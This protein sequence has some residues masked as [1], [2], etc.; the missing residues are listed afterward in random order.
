MI[1]PAK[2]AMVYHNLGVLLNAGMPIIKSFDTMAGNS[3][4]GLKKIF[5]EIAK[6]LSA[7]E[8][9]T[10]AM[11]RYDRFFSPLD[12][13]MVK[14]GDNSGRLPQCFQLLSKWYDFRAKLQRIVTSGLI[15]PLVILHIAIPVASILKLVSGPMTIR[16]YIFDVL[17]ALFTIY[18]SVFLLF[19]LYRLMRKVGFINYFLDAVILLVP[20]LGRGIKHLSI[21]KYARAFGMLYQSGVPITECL[22]ESDSLAGNR[23]VSG[24][25]KGGSTSVANGQPAWAGFSRRLPIEYLNLWQLGEETGELDKMADKIGEIAGDKAELWL[26]A[27]AKG[28]P[29]FVYFLICIWMIFQI[30]K[31]YTNLFTIPEF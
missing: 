28:F 29:K 1:K 2:I 20:V 10:D 26:T 6:A 18:I 25:F 13:K 22:Q 11:S 9:L 4:G 12:I 3:Q 17:G 30:S 5:N 14:A 19:I 31:G 23:V 15:F 24:Y 7:G 16:G 21:S 8:S 27:F